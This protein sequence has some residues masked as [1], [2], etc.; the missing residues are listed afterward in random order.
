MSFGAFAS[1]NEHIWEMRK[2]N[3]PAY[4]MLLSKKVEK[5]KIEDLFL[6][7]H[8]RKSNL[9][10][11]HAFDARSTGRN[12]LEKGKRKN[13]RGNTLSYIC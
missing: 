2:N 7:H 4:L 8:L 1:D 12:M 10:L 13:R 11:Y 6:E 9:E 3:R 5:M